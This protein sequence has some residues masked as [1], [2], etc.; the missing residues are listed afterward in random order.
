MEMTVHVLIGLFLGV[1]L[2]NFIKPWGL[3]LGIFLGF[4]AGVYN[5]FKNKSA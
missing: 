2:N 4:A 3:I 5:V 1:Y